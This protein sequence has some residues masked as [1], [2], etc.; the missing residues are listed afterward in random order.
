MSRLPAAER[1]EQL[2]DTA[3][4]LFAKRGYA[5]TTTAQLA[6]A[7]GITEPVLYRHF[8]SKRDLFIA[9]IDRTS[10]DVIAGWEREIRNASTPAEQIQFLLGANPMTIDR[11]RGTYRVVVQGLTEI[12]DR[13]IRKAIKRHMTRLHDFLVDRLTE[14]KRTGHLRAAKLDPE[15]IA[16]MLVHVA[17]GYGLIAPLGIASH[18]REASG[19]HIVRVLN[20]LLVR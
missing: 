13:E 6:K 4:E 18:G 5:R 2:L 7:A 14:V 19:E 8:A 1:R 3:A 16:W 17:L 9:L 15:L 10:D 20:R 11:G 12:D